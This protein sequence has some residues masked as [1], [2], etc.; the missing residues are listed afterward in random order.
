LCNELVA[1]WEDVHQQDKRLWLNLD[2]LACTAELIEAIVKLTLAE[3][4]QHKPGWAADW[5]PHT[6]YTTA[7]AKRSREM[8]PLSR[9]GRRQGALPKGIT[10]FCP[11]GEGKRKKKVAGVPGGITP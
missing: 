10:L 6:P 9:G 5:P 7:V 2:P 8:V 4:V 11:R 1:Q 3:A